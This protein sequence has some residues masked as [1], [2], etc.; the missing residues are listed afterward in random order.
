MNIGMRGKTVVPELGSYHVVPKVRRLEKSGCSDMPVDVHS[1]DQITKMYTATLMRF[2]VKNM[3]SILM[4][5]HPSRWDYSP[6]LSI[7]VVICLASMF[8]LWCRLLISS[9]PYTTSSPA[10]P[11]SDTSSCS[12]RYRFVHMP[13]VYRPILGCTRQN[14][15]LSKWFL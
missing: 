1:V 14:V 8:L 13:V 5:S 4:S 6:A 9:R 2:L 11:A 12:R 3:P 10:L 7:L 15:Q